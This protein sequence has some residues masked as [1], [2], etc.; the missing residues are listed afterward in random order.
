[1]KKIS[2]LALSILTLGTIIISCEKDDICAEATPTTP[3]LIIEF[4]DVNSPEELKN[5]TGLLV[6][7]IGDDGEGFLLDGQI[8]SD[9]NSVTIPLRTD[10]NITKVVLHKDYDIEDNIVLGNPETFNISYVREDIYVSRACGYKT[11]FND[12]AANRED[13]VDNWISSIVIEENTTVEN[14]TSAHVKIY[15]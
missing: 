8:L 6:Y 10:M 13:D 5:V 3:Q 4:Y 11:I 1:M 14:E 7:G 15:H 12:L 2:L 9:K